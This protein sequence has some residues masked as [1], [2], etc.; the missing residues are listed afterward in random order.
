[1]VNHYI[2]IVACSTWYYG[3]D[4]DKI[5]KCNRSNTFSFDDNG[6]CTCKS[7][8]FGESCDCTKSENDR[9]FRQGEVCRKGICTCRDGYT[10]A[11]RGCRGKHFYMIFI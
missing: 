8:W 7:S 5:T 10:R 1:M 4:C 6:I 9:C 2:F 3:A 11:G